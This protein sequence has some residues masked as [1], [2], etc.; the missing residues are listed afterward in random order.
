ML[1][2]VTNLTIDPPTGEDCDATRDRKRGTE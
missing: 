2:V 1:Q